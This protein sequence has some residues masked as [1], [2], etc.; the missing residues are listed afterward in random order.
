M[1]YSCYVCDILFHVDSSC[2]SYRHIKSLWKK[3]SYVLFLFL[4]NC[5]H[6]FRFL[7]C[8]CVTNILIP[9]IRQLE[10]LCIPG[11]LELSLNQKKTKLYK[12]GDTILSLI[13][14][15]FY[16]SKLS[17]TT[18]P[19]GTSD[20]PNVTNNCNNDCVSE[21]VEHTRQICHRIAFYFNILQ[22]NFIED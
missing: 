18:T 20:V 8:W 15:R 4:S 14:V 17:A 21:Q 10:I 2:M 7:S 3:K 6:S 5:R 1:N 11:R 22:N 12:F 9:K 19:S 13:V 16:V